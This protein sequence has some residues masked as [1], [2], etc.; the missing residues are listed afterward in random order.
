MYPKH[1]RVKY[2]YLFT[3]LL[4]LV[5]ATLGAQITGSPLTATT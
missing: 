5:S 2:H 3:Y 1:L 4:L